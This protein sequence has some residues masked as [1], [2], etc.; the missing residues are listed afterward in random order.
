ME[1]EAAAIYT[2]EKATLYH[3]DFL[4]IAGCLEDDSVDL[5]FT[6]PPF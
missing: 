5:V 4:N 3:A 2:T 6:D 1:K